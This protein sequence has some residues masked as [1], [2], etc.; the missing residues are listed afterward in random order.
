MVDK[1]DA[2]GKLWEQLE[3]FGHTMIVIGIKKWIY[4]SCNK[5]GDTLGDTSTIVKGVGPLPFPLQKINPWYWR[6]LS[7]QSRPS[8]PWQWDNEYVVEEELNVFF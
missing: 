7:N 5:C 6:R 3:V 4:I 1:N 8:H 2:L